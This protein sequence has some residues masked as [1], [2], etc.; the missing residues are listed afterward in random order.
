MRFLAHPPDLPQ[1]ARR[2]VSEWVPEWVDDRVFNAV[3]GLQSFLAD[4]M[5][6]NG[7]TYAGQFDQRLRD[8]AGALRSD[9]AKAASIGRG[10]AATA[11]P[12]RVRP[13]CRRCG[14]T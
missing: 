12:P 14:R 7:T 10:Q 1:A 9:P 5:A 2:G 3:T 13:G 11:R 4:V 8:Y 6:D